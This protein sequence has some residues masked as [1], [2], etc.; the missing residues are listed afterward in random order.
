MERAAVLCILAVVDGNTPTPT[1]EPLGEP[2]LFSPLPFLLSR[3]LPSANAAVP[4]AQMSPFAHRP[5]LYAS[6]VS[7]VLRIT[8]GLRNRPSR[9]THNPLTLP[10]KHTQ[11]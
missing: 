2:L 8:K 10:L 5:D 4:L 3:V 6:P 7:T 9:Q 1:F 11:S